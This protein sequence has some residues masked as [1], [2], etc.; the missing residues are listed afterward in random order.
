[1]LTSLTTR[2]KAR[3]KVLDRFLDLCDICD[4]A[5]ADPGSALHAELSA[6]GVF[7]GDVAEER[8]FRHCTII[9]QL[10][11]LYESFSEA[12]LGFWLAR[13]PHY[14]AFNDLPCSFKNAY[15]EGIARIV[16]GS[17]KRKYRHL[18]LIDVLSK[19]LSSLS[20]ESPWEFVGEALTTHERNLRRSEFEQLFHAAGLNGVWSFLERGTAIL[21]LTQEGDTDKSLDGMILDLVTYRN[22]ASHGTPD[23]I[24]GADTLRQWIAFIEAFCDTLALFVTHRIVTEEAAHRPEALYGVVTE[25]FRDNVAVVR[26]DRGKFCLGDHLFF[27]RDCDCTQARIDSLQVDDID[28]TCVEIEHAGFEVGIRTSVRV[29]RGA[30]VVRVDERVQMGEQDLAAD[31]KDGAAEG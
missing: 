9:T 14:R 7:G 16:H 17:E 29:R 10:Y 4:D 30:R 19:Y 11:G 18:V 21:E 24:L 27:L 13:L 5:A 31:A 23:E 6:I 22:D 8:V 25:T 26:C 2:V 1:M 12:A 20:G 15:R 28:H 3:A